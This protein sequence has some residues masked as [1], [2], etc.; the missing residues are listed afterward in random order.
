MNA[1]DSTETQRTSRT[2]IATLLEHCTWPA[3]AL[4][5]TFELG[6]VKQPRLVEPPVLEI[7]C[8]DGT[9]TELAGLH[10]DLAIDRNP[11]AVERA[12]RRSGVYDRVEQADLHDLRTENGPK[13]QTLFA[14]S[15]LEHVTDVER[16]L[17]VCCELLRPGG[18]LVTTVP[19]ADM[20]HHLAVRRP[21]YARLRARQ[22][23][24]RNLWSLREWDEKLRRAGF[25]S[26]TAERYLDPRN[27]RYWDRL[28][29]VGGWGIGRYRVAV[30]IRLLAEFLLPRA[31]RSRLK[32]A[33]LDRFERRQATAPSASRDGCA[34]LL[35]ATKAH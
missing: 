34:A 28:D 20:N 9:F 24:H 11:R 13:Y 6:A 27:C 30:G 26:V 35:V 29:F 1:F 4:W 31:V 15:V 21:G 2:E 18:R 22:L 8:G 19:L 10:V 25:A 14:N 3:E 16:V 12:R 5:R 17:P 23:Q 33:L 7:G 32:L